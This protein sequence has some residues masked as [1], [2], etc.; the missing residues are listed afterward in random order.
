MVDMSALFQSLGGLDQSLG[1]I[2][3]IDRSQ[4]ADNAS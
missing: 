1:D 3:S 2:I 4:I